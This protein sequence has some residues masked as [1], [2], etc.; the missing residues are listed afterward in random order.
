MFKKI[1]IAIICGSL[2]TS[3]PALIYA[4]PSLSGL[5][6]NVEETPI[7][8][9]KIE[10][11]EIVNVKVILVEENLLFLNDKAKQYKRKYGLFPMNKDAFWIYI[12]DFTP[13][14][15]IPLKYEEF[16]FFRGCGHIAFSARTNNISIILNKNHYITYEGYLDIIRNIGISPDA[17]LFVFKE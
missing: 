15:E 12:S 8:P 9:P 14:D 4:S 10:G 5:K 1:A 6:E 13:L 11:T 17:N 16:E 3:F 7:L 2:F